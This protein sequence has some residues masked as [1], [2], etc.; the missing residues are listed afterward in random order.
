LQQTVVAAVPVAVA[1]SDTVAVPVAVADSAAV[2][3]VVAVAVAA[4][5]HTWTTVNFSVPEA[6]IP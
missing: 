4:K 2:A 5:V 6:G 3:V 1:D